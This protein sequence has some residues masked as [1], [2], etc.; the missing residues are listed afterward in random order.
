MT[1]IRL[2][3]GVWC[4]LTSVFVNVYNGILISF[5]TSVRP[6][7]PLIN[8]EVDVAT[9]PNVYLLVNIGLAGDIWFSVS[10][11]MLFNLKCFCFQIVSHGY[12]CDYTDGR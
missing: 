11:S 8:S 7:P 6:T 3:V 1:K 10:I 2:V 9:D 5:V 4:L 12:L